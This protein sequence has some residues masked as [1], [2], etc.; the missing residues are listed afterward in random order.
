MGERLL[1]AYVIGPSCGPVV[2]C[3][4]GLGG[5][6]HEWD[7][8]AAALQDEVTVVCYDRAGYGDSTAARDGRSLPCLARDLLAVCEST[9]PQ[10][11]VVLVG[12]SLGGRIARAAAN[13]GDTLDLRGVVL[14]EGAPDG[15]PGDLPKVAAEQARFLRGASLLAPL[16]L[17]RIPAVKRKFMDSL[18]ERDGSSP[19]LQE[20]IRNVERRRY[21]S[22]VRSEWK[23]MGDPLPGSARPDLP[24]VGVFAQEWQD[25]KPGQSRRFGVTSAELLVHLQGSFRRTFPDGQV[26]T[27]ARSGHR[28]HHDQPAVVAGVIRD[29]INREVR[30]G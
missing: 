13:L 1:A 28:I 16:G 27:V 24:A 2:V 21:W 6:H 12:H 5:G 30:V 15:M 17:V 3:E 23:S 26:V 29:L 11:P 7:P 22:A 10:R 4:S 25:W 9:A 14:I 20:M 19:V 18:G 8:I